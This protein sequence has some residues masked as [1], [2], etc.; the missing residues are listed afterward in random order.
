MHWLERWLFPPTC[1]ISG[2]LTEKLDL[3]PEY[4]TRWQLDKAR[5]PVCA[6]PSPEAQVCG[7][8]LHHPPAFIRSQVGFQFT[9][10]LRELIHQ[11][12]YQQQLYL[13]R[14]FAECWQQQLQTQGIQALVPI[15]LHRKRLRERGYNQALELARMLSRELKI[16]VVNAL[17]RQKA[18]VSQTGLKAS[19][20]VKNLKAAFYAEAHKLQGLKHIALI[21][22][23]M[24]TGATMHQAAKTLTEV[25]PGLVVEAWA[26]A[27]TQ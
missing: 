22:D 8:C 14:L 27:K 5:C 2:E 10:E 26:L 15:P 12:K 19:Q 17:N 21:D 25:Q 18:T 13:S 1:V 11:Y 24:T 6:E 9:D 20:R 3:K 7:V 23:V 16:P 4:L